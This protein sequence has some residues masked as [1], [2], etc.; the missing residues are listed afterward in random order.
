MSAAKRIAVLVSGGGFYENIPRS[1]PDGLGAVI[2]RSAVRI[3]PIFE[4]IQ[5]TGSIP[6]RDMFNT[7]NMGTGMVLIVDQEDVTK[8]VAALDAAGQPSRVI[9]KVVPGD[10]GVELS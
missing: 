10:G 6:E 7:F 9:G 3:L 1:I 4:L 8:A 2:D 5:K